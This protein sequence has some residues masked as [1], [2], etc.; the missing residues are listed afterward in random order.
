[1]RLIDRL[2]VSMALS[3]IIVSAAS[4]MPQKINY[5]G[6]LQDPDGTPITTTTSVEF[7]IYDAGIGGT[8]LWMET[9]SVTPDVAGRFNVHLGRSIPIPDSV[10]E[11]GT[12]YLGVTIPPDP[13]MSPRAVC[14]GRVRVPHS[15][16]G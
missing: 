6:I 9:Q 13:E 2:A 1:M 15:H 14:R 4:A 10:F 11:T 16:S 5:Q 12:A 3:L 7:R 8:R